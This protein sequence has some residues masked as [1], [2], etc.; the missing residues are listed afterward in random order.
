MVSVLGSSATAEVK[1]SVS[2][3]AG[4]THALA[5][6]GRGRRQT[7]GCRHRGNARQWPRRPATPRR[8]QGDP[9]PA[10][11]WPSVKI[12]IIVSRCRDRQREPVDSPVTGDLAAVAESIRRS[13]RGLGA[14]AVAVMIIA[15]MPCAT[16]ASMK[17]MLAGSPGQLA[18][19]QTSAS[20]AVNSPVSARP[21]ICRRWRRRCDRPAAPRP[22][23]QEH[24]IADDDLLGWDSDSIRPAAPAVA[25]IIDQRAPDR[26]G[27][28]PPA[29]GPRP[30]RHG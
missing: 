30:R 5:R 15:P 28:C 3:E 24:D 22:G 29:A 19:E 6:P 20:L 21:L 2:T 1:P 25:F 27:L 11:A 8:E 13:S 16:G 14:G 9:R 23:G 17:A 4:P 18:V 12:T 26:V 7:D 10:A